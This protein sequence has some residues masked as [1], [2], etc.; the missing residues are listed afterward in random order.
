M[1]DF[2]ALYAAFPGGFVILLRQ[3]AQVF[4]ITTIDTP[5]LAACDNDG[6]RFLLRLD[7]RNEGIEAMDHSKEVGVENLPA[8]CVSCNSS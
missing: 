1:A 4:T 5:L 3:L 8:C 2:D 6:G 7:I